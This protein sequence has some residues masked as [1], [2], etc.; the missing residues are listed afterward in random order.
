MHPAPSSDK[1]FFKYRSML[2]P[3]SF[4]PPAM[5]MRRGM[6]RVCASSLFRR[7]MHDEGG[8]G[9]DIFGIR[10]WETMNYG[11]SL[12]LFSCVLEVHA[13]M[14]PM[15]DKYLSYSSPIKYLMAIT[16]HILIHFKSYPNAGL[17]SSLGFQED[18]TP[19]FPD[20]RHMQVVS[21]S[22]LRTSRFYPPQLYPV[23]ISVDSND[24]IRN[25]TRDLP[26]CSTVPPGVPHTL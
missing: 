6:Q 9:R 20:K 25:R 17:S 1:S 16:F 7:L 22:T 15:S 19:R 2:F 26:D 24:S 8:V 4:K 11:F 5:R 10:P 21:L 3:A 12:F 23:L 18:E 14:S 13:V